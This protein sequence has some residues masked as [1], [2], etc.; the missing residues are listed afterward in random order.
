MNCDP[1]LCQNNATCVP[2]VEEFVCQCKDVFFGKYC[3]KRISDLDCRSNQCY[4]SGKC[5]P[6]ENND[7]YSCKC[8]LGYYGTFCQN[9]VSPCARLPCLNHGYCSAIDSN[10]FKCYCRDGYYGLR[11]ERCK[12]LIK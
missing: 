5:E 3:E 2:T 11:C 7:F 9:K 6:S 12:K 1:N 8:N 10:A 4:N